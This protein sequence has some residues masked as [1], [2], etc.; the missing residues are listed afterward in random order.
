LQKNHERGNENFGDNIML[1]GEQ[2]EI[3]LGSYGGN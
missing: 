3:Q 1:I 2:K